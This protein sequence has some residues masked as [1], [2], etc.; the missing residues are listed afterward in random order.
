MASHN[1]MKDKNKFNNKKLVNWMK[2]KL[3]RS[4]KT[5]CDKLRLKFKCGW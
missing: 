5:T 2:F 3:D 1:Y 4:L